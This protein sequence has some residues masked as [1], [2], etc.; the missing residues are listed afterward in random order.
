MLRIDPV[1][2]LTL[3][4]AVASLFLASVIH[5]IRDPWRFREAVRGFELVPLSLINVAAGAVFIAEFAV[6]M[7]FIFGATRSY[8]M[9]IAAGVVTLY[10]G[11]IGVNL[12]RGRTRIDCGCM[13]FSERQP[14]AKWMVARNLI[15]AAAALIACLPRSPRELMAWDGF[16]IVCAAL[17][18]VGLYMAQG[19]LVHARQRWQGE[20]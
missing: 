16:V 14:L 4:S 1:L 13:G 18:A 9:L 12:I 19:L 11:A 2:S 20:S 17:S 6:V 5:K 8:G 10:A 3:A 7:L 15:I